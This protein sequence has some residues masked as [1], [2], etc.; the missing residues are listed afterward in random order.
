MTNSISTLGGGALQA[1]NNKLATVNDAKAATGKTSTLPGNKCITVDEM[2][3]MIGSGGGDREV[4]IDPLYDLMESGVS[5]LVLDYTNSDNPIGMINLECQG[6]SDSY[7]LQNTGTAVCL[8]VGGRGDLT[9]VQSFHVG[10]ESGDIALRYIGI[11]KQGSGNYWEVES[12]IT[13]AS[14]GADITM[15]NTYFKILAIAERSS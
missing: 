9:T 10:F 7:D 6:Y 13:D 5:L 1:A 3:A 15:D 2:N 8:N 12:Y 11:D 4:P 14:G